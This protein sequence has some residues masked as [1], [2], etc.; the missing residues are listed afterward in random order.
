ME[1]FLKLAF[2][3]IKENKVKFVACDSLLLLSNVFIAEFIL[4]DRNINF[5]L[6]IAPIV[7]SILFIPVYLLF[8]NIHKISEKYDFLFLHNEYFDILYKNVSYVLGVIFILLNIVFFQLVWVNDNFLERAIA[9]YFGVPWAILI[10]VNVNN[11]FSQ[12]GN[13]LR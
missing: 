1:I 3:W 5:E 13:K 9:I 8:G 7:T 10:C 4:N 2:D 6:I 11:G 12:K